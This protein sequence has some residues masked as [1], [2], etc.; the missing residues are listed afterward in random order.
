ML[1]AE[2]CSESHLKPAGG[3]LWPQAVKY[4]F[5][6]GSMLRMEGRCQYY[7]WHIQQLGERVKVSDAKGMEACGH[8]R[9]F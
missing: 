8:P 3:N 2:I 9:T 7:P 5:P 6:G 1:I 4:G